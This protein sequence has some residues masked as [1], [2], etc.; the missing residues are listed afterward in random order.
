M[1]T[2]TVPLP[3]VRAEEMPFDCATGPSDDRARASLR[4]CSCTRSKRDFLP[5]F[6]MPMVPCYLCMLHFDV[7]GRD[8]GREKI[9]A[10]QH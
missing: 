4:S 2:S 5:A 1:S 10:S 7:R 9:A 6:L 3:G 8:A